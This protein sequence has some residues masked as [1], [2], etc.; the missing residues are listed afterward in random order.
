MTLRRALSGLS[1]LALAGAAALVP[2]T[3]SA[4]AAAIEVDGARVQFASRTTA[5]ASVTYTC[6]TPGST[7]SDTLTV[8][9]FQ[10]LAEQGYKAAADN[11]DEG[12]PVQCDGVA[13]AATPVALQVR[14]GVFADGPAEVALLVGDG[15]DEDDILYQDVDVVGVPAP[16][17]TVS[18]NASPEP[19]RKGKKITVKGT[20]ARDDKPVKVKA[21]LYFAK[22]GGDF[23]KVKT[24]KSDKKGRLSTTVKASQS[25]TFAYGY[26]G[27]VD[28]GDHVEVIPVAKTYK[29]CTALNKVYENGVGKK[30]AVDKGGSVDDFTVDDATYK[31]N[32]KS[33]RDKDGIACER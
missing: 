26:G 3:A 18:T 21:T 15:L 23:T 27:V 20:V 17:V 6:G 14:E 12:T 10:P 31:K 11:G 22:D 16:E 30:G 28:D 29:N 33:D 24:V 5:S 13:H 19:A 9:V 32:K 7:V 1:L 2:G 25:G 4:A 8:I